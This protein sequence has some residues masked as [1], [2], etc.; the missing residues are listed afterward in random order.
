MPIDILPDK[1]AVFNRDEWDEKI[2]RSYRLRDPLADMRDGTQPAN[3]AGALADQLQIMSYNARQIGQSIPLSTCTLEQLEQRA[4][5]LGIPGLTPAVGSAGYVSINAPTG[6]TIFSGDELTDDAGLGLVF[7]CIRTDTYYSDTPVPV[8]AISVGP[9]SNLD[10][11]TAL[12]WSFPRAG[13]GP[14]A[15]VTAQPDGSGLTNGRDEESRDEFEQRISDSLA[16]PAVAGND[17]A[18]QRLLESSKAHGVPVQKSFTVPAALGPGTMGCAILLKPSRL[19]AQ[20]IANPVQS[21]QVR[22]YVVG[23]LPADDGYCEIVIEPQPEDI[24]LD[25]SWAD[26]AKV[27][28]DSV[29]WPLR[30]DP[31]GTPGAIVVT[32][33]TSPTSF[34]LDCQN[35]IRTGVVAP[36]VGKTIGF[37]NRTTGNFA[38]KKIVGVTGTGPWTIAVDITNDSSDTGYTPIVG[39]R[40]CP[41]SDS[42]DLLVPPVLKHFDGLGPGEQQAVFFDPGL[43]QKRNP[44]APKFWPYAIGNRL[45]GD[46]L[47]ETFV[48]DAVI[49]EGLGA[50][51]AIGVPGTLLYLI[52]LRFITAFPLT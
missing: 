33:A 22:D 18:Y 36:T 48:Q 19:G 45:A 15:T 27:W 10:A 16:N 6:A 5:E 21:S 8:V 12:H 24:V 23:Q 42:L 17:A 47:K 11:G 43:K 49:R 3:D 2:R 28:V 26:G 35:G 20:R 41:W 50:T 32:S 29:P 7:Q 51:A 37:L 46:I 38:R 9:K 39:Q 44:S 14:A 30:Y 4:Q 40:C 34:V 25:V 31:A 1:L 13:C 52:E